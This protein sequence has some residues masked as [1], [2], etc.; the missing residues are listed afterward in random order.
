[1]IKDLLDRSGHGFHVTN[2]RRAGMV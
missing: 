1:V 2:F